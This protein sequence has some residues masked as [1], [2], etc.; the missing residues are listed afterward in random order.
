M[1]LQVYAASLIG[2]TMFTNRMFN[3]ALRFR[4]WHVWAIASS[5]LLMRRARTNYL[6]RSTG[7]H[8]ISFDRN[9]WEISRNAGSAAWITAWPQ[10]AGLPSLQSQRVEHFRPAEL[11][12]SNMHLSRPHVNTELHLS[13]LHVLELP[14]FMACC[15]GLYPLISYSE[16]TGCVGRRSTSTTP[17]APTSAAF[18]APTR[19]EGCPSEPFQ[20]QIRA[21]FCPAV[22]ASAGMAGFLV[23]RPG[24][25]AIAA[26]YCDERAGS[27]EGGRGGAGV[28]GRLQ[29]HGPLRRHH[30]LQQ[31]RPRP[32]ALPLPPPPP[33]PP[34]PPSLP[35]QTC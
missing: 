22:R 5:R 18:L 32:V 34:Q 27:E 20:A 28:H 3:S 29:G 9:V 26:R 13:N 1:K 12:G 24:P 23:L 6:T 14:L 8:P 31:A 11:P 30:R 7:T 19:S 17:T 4:E 35:S 25:T 15:P 10:A 21:L 2:Q 33:P 16:C